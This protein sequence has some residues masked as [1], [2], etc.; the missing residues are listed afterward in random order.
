MVKYTCF[1]IYLFYL[2]ITIVTIFYLLSAVL[3]VQNILEPC[4]N[5]NP[6]IVLIDSMNSEDEDRPVR[7]GQVAQ[8]IRR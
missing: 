4:E 7:S 1:D 8:I 2:S 6:C 3:N 5:S